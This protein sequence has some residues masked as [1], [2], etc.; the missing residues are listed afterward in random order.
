MDGRQSA[1]TE[2]R[3]V[4]IL[5]GATAFEPPARRRWG[6]RLAPVLIA[7]AGVP[8]LAGSFA[9]N[10]T[11]SGSGAVEFGQGSQ[12]MTVCDA[13]FTVEVGYAWRAAT[14]SFTVDQIL[15]SGIDTAACAGKTIELSAWSNTG[16][17]DVCDVGGQCTADG[18]SHSVGVGASSSLTLLVPSGIAPD[19]IVRVAVTTR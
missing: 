16:Q 14:S 13:S 18:L 10:I 8:M 19:D 12:A 1:S 3:S 6:L 15:V 7:A 17:V 5:A 11:L 2:L 9:S 4:L